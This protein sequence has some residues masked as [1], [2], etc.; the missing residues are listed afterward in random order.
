[1]RVATLR[2]TVMAVL[3]AAALVACAPQQNA[4]VLPATRR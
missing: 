3:G 4:N 1:M 2:G